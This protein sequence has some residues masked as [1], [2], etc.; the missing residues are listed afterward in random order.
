M[1]D[2]I[3]V[4]S[5]N[6]ISI[7]VV[8]DT[9]IPDRVDGLHPGLIPLLKDLQPNY[10]FHTGDISVL[11]IIDKLSEIAPVFAVA[12]NRDFLNLKVLSRHQMFLINGSRILLT[13]GHIS[14]AH[15]WVDK[16]Q[17][18]LQDYQIE[19][20]VKRFSGRVE[21]ADI[22]IFGHSH[23]AENR[24]VDGK[25]YFNPGSAS[26]AL[27]PEFRISFGIMRIDPKGKAKG[28]IV[29]L[30]G[31]KIRFGKWISETINGS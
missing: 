30:T 19:R 16:I 27:R 2:P 24:W 6:E 31:A 11:R 8:G 9:H 3:E 28:E 29:D 22:Y 15:Y 14:L 21:K 26:I 23:H 1:N 7:A 20:Y 18:W 17:N 25:L 5:P 10:I 4:N 12:G 13:H